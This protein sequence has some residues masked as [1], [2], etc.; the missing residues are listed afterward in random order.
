MKLDPAWIEI[1]HRER[2]KLHQARIEIQP[3]DIIK[4]L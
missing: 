3:G 1:Q 2:M 4:W